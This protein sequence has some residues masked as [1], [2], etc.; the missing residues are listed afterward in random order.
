MSDALPKSGRGGRRRGAGRP[1]ISFERRL[2][3]GQR[4]RQIVVDILVEQL[5]SLE[6]LQMERLRRNWQQLNLLRNDG[7]KIDVGERDGDEEALDI[8]AENIEL[9]REMR[10]ED[11]GELDPSPNEQDV[12]RGKPVFQMSRSTWT[13]VFELARVRLIDELKAE[14]PGLI[15]RGKGA[16]FLRR[17]WTLC[18]S[19]D[20]EDDREHRGSVQQEL[21]SQAQVALIKRERAIQL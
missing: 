15:K 16:A 21:L 9:I 5:R 19:I 18:R 4:Y 8:A 17:C 6:K 13:T 10:G 1:S 20:Q 14:H 3:V 7:L 11:L 2:Q 12:L